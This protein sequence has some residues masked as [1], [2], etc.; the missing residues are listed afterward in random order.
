MSNGPTTSS[1]SKH[2]KDAAQNPAC[3][4]TPAQ[5]MSDLRARHQADASSPLGVGFLENPVGRRELVFSN[6][7]QSQ[8]I[9][10]ETKLARSTFERIIEKPLPL[11]ETQLML[12][13][14]AQAYQGRFPIML[15][16]GTAIGKT[17]T[18]NLFSQ[19]LYGEG[20]KIPDIYC[21][22]QTDVAE[23]TGKYVPSGMTPEQHRKVNEFLESDKGAGLKAELIK[24]G[25]GNYEHQ[26]L[27]TR[28][29]AALGLPV[30]RSQF[31]FQ[32]GILPKAMTAS[33]DD[34]GMLHYGPD[35]EGVMLHV[36]EVGM[37]PPGVANA[38]LQL[39]GESGHLTEKIHIWEDGGRE[40]RAGKGF[41]V[42]FS[43]NPPGSG[44]QERF[45]VDQ[46]LA[47]GMI[48]VNLPERLSEE[49]LRTAARHIFRCDKIPADQGTVIDLGRANELAEVLGDLCAK[50]HRLYE[51]ETERGE[52]GRRQK[53]P[54]TI[55]SLWRVAGLVQSVQCLTKDGSSVD[56]VA[57]LRNAIVA[58]Y[59]DCLQDKAP[60][61]PS[62]ALKDAGKTSLGSRVLATFDTLLA[63]RNIHGLPFRGK[64]KV[65]CG[66]VIQTLTRELLVNT[67]P[68][69]D[70]TVIERA[71]KAR[72]GLEIDTAIRKL[73]KLLDPK[74]AA[75]FSAA[76]SEKAPRF[77]DS[78]KGGSLN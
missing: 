1:R 56:M 57:T 30:D 8:T 61:V 65:A 27:F 32:L 41:F 50:F 39:R 42:V 17:Y 77:E 52:T 11:K 29:C 22:G 26:E 68:A 6:L 2:K 38:L 12:F 23:L 16:G 58:V 72:S 14:L 70:S 59:I 62:K 73:E 28:A 43:T 20:A 35:G 48:W 45:P 69:N 66:E 64:E 31:E 9:A 67:S 3:E 49:S 47:R 18:V 63:D 10:L 75:K 60:L 15:E 44:F 53:V 34:K 46:A 24:A 71:K 54:A 40:I 33:H 7:E 37:A 78:G 74:L 36:Q 5:T 19:L 25:K 21:N 55:D 76:I 4:K 13:K 51:G